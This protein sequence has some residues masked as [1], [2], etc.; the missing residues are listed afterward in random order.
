MV[1]GLAASALRCAA[2][3]LARALLPSLCPLCREAPPASPSPFCFTCGRSLER[4]LPPYCSSCGLPFRGAGPSHD[5][6]RCRKA[7]PPF[8]EL[9]SWGL[10]R[11]A[12][13]ES[14]HAFKYRRRTAFRRA[15]ETL[16]LQAFD[17]HWPG[18]SFAAVVPVPPSAPALRR[19]GFDLP[20]LLAR[21]VG[22]ARGIPWR[23]TALTKLRDTPDFVGLTVE[24]R[25]RAAAEAYRERE[26][27]DGEVLLV[28]DVAT[29][30]ATARACAAA[31]LEAGAE[32]VRVLVLARTALDAT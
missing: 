11:G 14:V 13:R 26:R 6:N 9:R 28:D 21:S 18:R 16:A 31:C 5:C 15:L 19:R 20:T 32:A 1:A 23:P 30:A 7:P 17:A 2:E 24:E 10:Y 4:L 22:R 8:R 12:L 29:T 27:L 25:S 3:G